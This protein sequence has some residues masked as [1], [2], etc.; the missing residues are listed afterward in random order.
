MM[1]SVP[2]KDAEVVC[3]LVLYTYLSEVFVHSLA[4]MKGNSLS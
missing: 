2:F 3:V 1:A 4:G